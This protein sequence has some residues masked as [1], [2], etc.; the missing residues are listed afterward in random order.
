MR[1]DRLSWAVVSLLGAALAT[2]CGSPARL[3]E[4]GVDGAAMRLD[5]APAVTGA[6]AGDLVT[7]KALA[8][9]AVASDPDGDRVTFG[10]WTATCQ[11]T[12]GAAV[13]SRAGDVFGSTT[14][15]T[16]TPG[17]APGSCTL[18]VTAS[19]GRGGAGTASVTFALGGPLFT[20]LPGP[21]LLAPGESASFVVAVPPAGS[22]TVAWTDGLTAPQRG[23]FST[24]ALGAARGA[25]Y[26]P[27]RCLDLG[28][29]DHQVAVTATGTEASTGRT[30]SRRF[31]V[32]VRCPPA[33]TGNV[34]VKV[35]AIN[36]LHGQIV[37]GKA[38]GGLPVG[39]AAVLA[40]HLK[41]AMAG[42]EGRT[43]IAEAG[44]L[45]GASPAASALLQDEPTIMFMNQL[46]NDRCGW[47]PPPDRQTPGVARF[48]PLFDPGCNLVGVPGNHE[49]DEGVD[50]LTRLLA[51]GN[52]AKGP[53][54]EDPWRGARFPV[55]S[56][57]IHTVD[58][59]P[60]FRPYVV[61]YLDGV[62]VGFIGAT[63]SSTPS[64]VLPSG[65]AGL[66]F[67]DEVAAIN[68][69]VRELQ[70]R[71]VHTIV[72]VLHG[73]VSQ[74]GSYTGPTNPAQAAPADLVALVARLDGEVDALITAHTHGFANEYVKNAAGR[75]VLVTQASSAGTA[76]ADI[77]LTVDG[78]TQDVVAATARVVTTSASAV[79]PDADALHLTTTAE[80]RV[81]PL[82][83]AV[84]GSTTAT[85]ARALNA[86]GE[87]TLGDLLAEAHRQS[88]GADFGITNPGGM[89]ADLPGTCATSPCPITWGDCFATQPFANQVMRV[90]LTGE[91][92]R[93]AL[94]QQF[95]GWAGQAQTRM[96]QIAG[97]RYG[98]SASAP[99]GSRVVSLTRADGTPIDP[100]A[101]YTV[102][103]NNFLQGGG[104]GFRVLAGGTNVVP[105]PIDLDALIAYLGA[106]PGPV[107]P[108]IDGRATQVP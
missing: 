45:V 21:V 104:D 54:L 11:G 74:T 27:A 59:E 105:G 95:A 69:Q 97:F 29:G 17:Q 63:L 62:Q 73:G 56:A 18:S 106:Q 12:F 66:V 33:A 42:V 14:T 1:I 67:E 8:V 26:T 102:A 16:A 94:E 44:D 71:G 64:I 72:V 22:W 89:R 35:L 90:T 83:R 41:G 92:L 61:K 82:V 47:M 60:L 2:G 84:V 101:S 78:R 7:G 46:A 108:S 87:S 40:A 15:F 39:S 37:A 65:V 85:L 49:F 23:T 75:D 9:T 38:V 20:T 77:D 86:G 88:M 76:Y 55:V 4:G 103:M 50:E 79:T 32:T 3:E 34:G 80:A 98:W 51:G 107:T 19:D 5:G 81:A 100:A 30:A 48:D 43:V 24:G 13:T 93:A 36:D 31:D 52:H 57:N 96:L 25:A 6:V 91:Q 10:R 68:A 99:L 58:G 28:L 53:F 70:R